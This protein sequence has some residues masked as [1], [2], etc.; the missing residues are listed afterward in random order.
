MPQVAT[1]EDALC[2]NDKT[3]NNRVVVRGTDSRF[4][5]EE[6]CTHHTSGHPH[7]DAF[8]TMTK[9]IN[10]CFM[11]VNRKSDSIEMQYELNLTR[12]NPLK[13]QH[14]M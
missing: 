5:Y 9:P 3:F 11:R 12:K 4:S 6:I 8:V 7:E 13:E 2:D 14:S 10:I 1:H